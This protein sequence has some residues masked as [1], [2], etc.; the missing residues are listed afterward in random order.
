MPPEGTGGT[1]GDWLELAQD[2]LE[3]ASRPPVSAKDYP[4]LCFYAQQAAEKA[5][6]AVLVS[7][8]ISFPF[9]HNIERVLSLVPPQ[10]EVPPEVQDGAALTAYAVD[11]RYVPQPEPPGEGDWR[12]AVAIAGAVVAWAEQALR[13]DLDDEA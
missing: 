13:E 2:D 10:V 8:D 12:E 4:R 11:F 7:R 5:I 6:K 9:V 3:F 1:A